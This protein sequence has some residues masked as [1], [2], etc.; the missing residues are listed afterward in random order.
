MDAVGGMRTNPYWFTCK[1]GKHTYRTV[2]NSGYLPVYCDGCVA[3][4]ANAR[5]KSWR[6][7][8]PAAWQV[9]AQRANET[10]KPKRRLDHGSKT[11]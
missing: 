10:R 1:C 5:N 6:R 8:N 3:D 7:R 4:K 9:I 11:G 2:G